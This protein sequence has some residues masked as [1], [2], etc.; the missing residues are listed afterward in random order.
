MKLLFPIICTIY[1]KSPW[2]FISTTSSDNCTG[3][4]LKAIIELTISLSFSFKALTAFFLVTPAWAITSS[5]SL[6]SRL[7]SSTSSPSSSSSSFLA[8]PDSMALAFP[9]SCAWLWPAC[10]SPLPAFSSLE[11]VI[12]LRAPSLICELR[13]SILASPK[14]LWNS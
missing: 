14:I 1:S 10:G 7:E 6:D 12:P 11:G 2:Q 5:I 3:Y 8:S 13:S 9:W 4:T